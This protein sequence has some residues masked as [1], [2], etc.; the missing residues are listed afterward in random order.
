MTDTMFTLDAGES[1]RP[2]FET[3]TN[4]SGVLVYDPIENVRFEL[5][6]PDEPSLRSEDVERVPFPVTAATTF[7]AETIIVPKLLNIYVRD[8]NFDLVFN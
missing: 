3:I 4:P 2:E 5:H 1:P 7:S 8:R 6:T